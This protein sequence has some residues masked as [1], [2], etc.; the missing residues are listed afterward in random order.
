VLKLLHACLEELVKFNSECS[1]FETWLTAAEEKIK[2]SRGK[3]RKPETLEQ[4]EAAHEVITSLFIRS[5][6]SC[7]DDVKISFCCRYLLCWPSKIPFE[8]CR[9]HVNFLFSDKNGFFMK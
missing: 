8:R 9:C 4:R 2:A 7:R 6:T 5:L 1:S 3:I